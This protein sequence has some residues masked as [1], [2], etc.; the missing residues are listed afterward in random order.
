MP[1]II[2]KWIYVRAGYEQSI[3]NGTTET[4]LHQNCSRE[5]RPEEKSHQVADIP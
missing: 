1:A 5:V 3:E 2:V 4:K